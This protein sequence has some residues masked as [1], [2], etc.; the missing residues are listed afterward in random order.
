LFLVNIFCFYFF[1]LCSKIYMGLATLVLYI[2]RVLSSTPSLLKPS[3]S[4]TFF[5]LSIDLF[6]GLP[7]LLY[8]LLQRFP[9]LLSLMPLLT[10]FHKITKIILI[11]SPTFYLHLLNCICPNKKTFLKISLMEKYY[12]A[13]VH[14]IQMKLNFDEVENYVSYILCWK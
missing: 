3:I 7:L 4:I 10:S 8:F 14:I 9:Y 6:F 13:Y 11:Y 12:I 1:V 2:H 5:I